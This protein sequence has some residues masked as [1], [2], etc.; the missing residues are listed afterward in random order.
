MVINYELIL[1]NCNY[2]L[3]HKDKIKKD[4][5]HFIKEMQKSKE[6]LKL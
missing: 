2:A 4:I 1:S 6:A 5:R 3:L